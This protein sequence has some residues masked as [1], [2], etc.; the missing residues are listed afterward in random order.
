MIKVSVLYQGTPS[1]DAFDMNYYREQHME[2]VRSR[3]GNAVKRI[4]IE[5][6][7]GGAAPGSPP[8]WVAGGH[9]YL[10]SMEAFQRWFVPHI[11]E[12]VA[13]IPNFTKLAPTVQISEVQ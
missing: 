10:D 6:G 11:P 7:L 12:F 2:L 3:C 4:E 9:L 1:E 13:D 8:T 5:K